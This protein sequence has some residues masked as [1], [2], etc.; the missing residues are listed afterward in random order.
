MI[1]AICT[2]L[3]KEVAG[4]EETF[5]GLKEILP[6]QCG[7]RQICNGCSDC[8]K[9]NGEILSLAKVREYDK[10]MFQMNEGRK[11]NE[12]SCIKWNL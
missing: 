10:K 1:I 11:S 5:T 12:S 9:C 2:F 4:M 3:I 8:G 6:I 7:I